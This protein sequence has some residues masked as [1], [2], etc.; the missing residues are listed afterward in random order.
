MNKG[1][2][3][4]SLWHSEHLPEY[5]CCSCSLETMCS[6]AAAKLSCLLLHRFEKHRKAKPFMGTW[7][8]HQEWP[9]QSLNYQDTKHRI[10]C[11]MRNDTWKIIEDDNKMFL[12]Q[13][14]VHSFIHYY[15]LYC[16]TTSLYSNLH[17]S[18]MKCYSQAGFK[19][20]RLFKG[21]TQN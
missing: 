8:V 11:S 20:F 6:R 19:C 14:M 9:S 12:L 2:E 1:K 5:F 10:S 4:E 21:F 13:F 17:C 7:A 18:S 16:L 3:G 15:S